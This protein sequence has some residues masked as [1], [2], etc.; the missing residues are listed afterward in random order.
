MRTQDSNLYSMICKRTYPGL[1]GPPPALTL[2][3]KCSSKILCGTTCLRV[4]P[5]LLRAPAPGQPQSRASQSRAWSGELWTPSLVL[6]PFSTPQVPPSSASPNLDLSP[7]GHCAVGHED[8]SPSPTAAG[9]KVP[10]TPL[11]SPRPEMEGTGWLWRSGWVNLSLTPDKFPLWKLLSG[12]KQAL[13]SWSGPRTQSGMV[14]REDQG[15]H[16]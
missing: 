14:L 6:L 10:S 11:P 15:Q 2:P 9:A 8:K 13:P 4:P 1:R 5:R 16:P 12:P 7:G 3:A